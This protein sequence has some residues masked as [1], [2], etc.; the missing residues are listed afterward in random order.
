MNPLNLKRAAVAH[1]LKKMLNFPFL[2]MLI[3]VRVG[4]DFVFIFV[5]QQSHL[6]IIVTRGKVQSVLGVPELFSIREVW[7][8]STK[9]FLSCKPDS[10]SSFN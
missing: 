8:K 7:I 1:F 9:D 4:Y 2:E 6:K 10:S 5:A 3:V